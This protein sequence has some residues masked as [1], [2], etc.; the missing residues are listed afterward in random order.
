MK[1]EIIEVSTLK[2][3]PRNYRKHGPDQLA[4]IAQSIK[5][6]GFYRN[7]VIASDGT[8]LAGHGAVEAAKQLK[9]KSVPVVRI[10]LKPTDKRALKILAGDNEV[11]KLGEV[12]DRAL[13]EILKEIVDDIDIDGLLGTGFDKQM[14][15]N[16]VF[17][18]RHADEISSFDAAKEWVGMPTYQE[19]DPT[20][21]DELVL[22]IVFKT[23]VDREQFVKDK[24]IRIA[25]TRG[26]RKWAT[27]WPWQPRNDLSSVKFQDT[28]K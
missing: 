5:A 15:A 10:N 23:T 1:T 25:S 17:V 7:V 2:A 6:N 4:H 18:T 9:I 16:L 27:M 14:L 3:H 11:M 26:G 20:K 13:S 8:I 19:D 28:K 12:D 21:K 24:E 22:V